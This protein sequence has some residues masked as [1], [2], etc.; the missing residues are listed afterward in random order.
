MTIRDSMESTRAEGPLAGRRQFLATAAAGLAV[1]AAPGLSFGQERLKQT[2]IIIGS[3]AGGATDKLARIYAEGLQ[4]RFA[5]TVIVENKAGAAGVIAYEYVK[6]RGAKDGSLVFLSPAYPIV[7]SPHVVS[8]LPYNPIRD[9]VG[10]GIAARSLMTF[11][12]GPAVPANIKTMPEYLQWCR[13]HPKQAVYAAQTGSAQ[14]LLGTSLALASKVPLENISYKGDAPGVQDVLGGH[15]PA[16]ILPA[17]SAIPYQKS[18]RMRVLATAARN[19]SSLMPEPPTFK[20]LGYPDI[21]FQDWLGIFAPAGTP[22][23]VVKRMNAAMA[24]VAKSKKGLELLD[25]LGFEADYATPEDFADII[26]ADYRRYGAII[27]KTGFRRVFEQA[28]GR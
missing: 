1:A 11:A 12:V 6:N 15:V 16:I 21:V 23:A 10:V 28:A 5:E 27:E 25:T 14:H 9:F 18:G 2:T 19:R 13:E 4:N 22:A 8:D 24:D 7:V 20:D 26:Q 3:P 17:A